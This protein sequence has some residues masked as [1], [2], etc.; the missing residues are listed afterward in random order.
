MENVAEQSWFNGI[1]FPKM[2]LAMD[3][4]R[5]THADPRSTE[6]LVQL[7][8]AAPDEDAAWEFIAV[9]HERGNH[10]VLEVAE[11]LCAGAT[12]KERCMGANLVAQLGAPEKAFP[13]EALEC[14]SEMLSLETEETVLAAIASALGHLDDPR[15]I[16]LLLPLKSHPSASVRYGVVQGVSGQN[17]PAAVQMLIE[18]S[19]DEDEETRD[20]A[21]FGL[22]TFIDTDTPE[23]REALWAR[24]NDSLENTRTEALMGLA[25]RKDKR[26]VAPLLKVLLSENVSPIHIEAAVEIGDARLL[27]ALQDLKECSLDDSTLDAEWLDKAIAACGGRTV[28]SEQ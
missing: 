27:P 6:E 15:C 1:Y 17:H 7:A 11:R 2:S 21:T 13:N 10:E 4:D 19:R 8:L 23:I 22:G 28:D 18:L 26:I 20:W 12:A 9:L 16:D 25:R 24:I 5:E 14:L 3:P